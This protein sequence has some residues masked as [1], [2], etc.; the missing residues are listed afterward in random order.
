MAF[1][2][3]QF[4]GGA[5]MYSLPIFQSWFE[6]FII[7]NE[8]HLR[9]MSKAFSKLRRTLNFLFQGDCVMFKIMKDGKFVWTIVVLLYWQLNDWCWEYL[10]ICRHSDGVKWVEKKSFL[11][12][13]GADSKFEGGMKRQREAIVRLKPIYVCFLWAVSKRIKIKE[14]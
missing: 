7:E 2:D 9:S 12:L 6:G 11:S 13:S 4:W 8:T 1:I 14:S 3:H 10:L 5:A